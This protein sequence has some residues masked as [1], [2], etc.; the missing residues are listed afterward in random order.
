MAKKDNSISRRRFIKTGSIIL[1]GSAL[2]VTK[3][4]ETEQRIE[5]INKINH[6][7][8]LG[9]TGFQASDISMGC[10]RNRESNVFRYAYDKGVNYFDTAESYIGGK[11]EKV[12]GDALKFMDRK[13]IFITTKLHLGH[14]ETKEGILERFRKCQERLQTEYVDCLFMHSVKD[15]KLLDH[16]GFH[17]AVKELKSQGRLRFC[18]VSSHGPRNEDQDSME[19]VLTAAAEDGQFDLM[20]LVYNFMN[21]EA[22]ENILKACKKNDVGTTAM[23]TAPGALKVE[24][25]DPENLTADQEK[26]MQRYQQRGMSEEKALQRLKRRAKEMEESVE[27]TKPFA[28]KYNL[29]SKEQLK[30]TS[31]QW[32]LQNPDMHTVCV[33]FSEFTQVDQTIPISGSEMS[34]L[35]HRLLQDYG[36]LFKSSYCRHG[37]HQCL[38]ACPH[39]LP[40]STI[41]RYAYY[42]QNQ[43]REKEAMV[44]YSRLQGRNG[45]FC[46]ECNAPCLNH[47]PHGVD[48]QAHLMHAHSNLTLA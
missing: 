11:S 32:V 21:A 34:Q 19:T 27:K 39:Q 38:S 7:R 43:G 1:A 6:H 46:A 47:C 25:V 9:R 10:T 8:K 16:A 29:T 40:V 45:T 18:G 28:K 44:K 5:K 12:L 48:I 4:K 41:F 37:C 22:G 15:V 13:K 36:T 35:D 23:K 30:L 3:A 26:L 14:E 20:L 31:I 24:P 17:D 33:S 42:F 2:S